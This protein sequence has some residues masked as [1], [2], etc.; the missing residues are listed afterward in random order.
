MF[1]PA[2]YWGAPRKSI[3]RRRDWSNKSRGLPKAL[4]VWKKITSRRKVVKDRI[5]TV[6]QED[7]LQNLIISVAALRK[8]CAGHKASNCNNREWQA[9]VRGVLKLGWSGVRNGRRVAELWESVCNVASCG[10]RYGARVT[11]IALNPPV[12]RPVPGEIVWILYDKNVWGECILFD[13]LCPFISCHVVFYREFWWM[14]LT[15]A[16]KES[17]LQ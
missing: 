6:H 10:V 14:K 7:R 16:N 8:R 11:G 2:R 1:T 12:K 5:R 9:A 15:E 3:S 4:K 17:E 13:Y